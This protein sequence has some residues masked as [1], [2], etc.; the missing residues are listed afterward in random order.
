MQAELV[1]VQYKAK[2]D[3]TLQTI[4]EIIVLGQEEVHQHHTD[5]HLIRLSQ[6]KEVPQGQC[7]EHLIMVASLSTETQLIKPFVLAP[8][9]IH[10][11][12]GLIIL[13]LITDPLPLCRLLHATV[14][15]A[16][17][18]LVEVGMVLTC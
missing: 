18:L 12:S 2:F 16:T 1:P 3:M 11:L 17:T 5:K 9:P 8:K 13:F 7:K 4:T 10:P 6:G 15:L 14:I